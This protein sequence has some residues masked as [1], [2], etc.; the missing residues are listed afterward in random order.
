MNLICSLLEQEMATPS[1]RFKSYTDFAKTTFPKEAHPV[2]IWQDIRLGRKG[3]QQPRGVSIEEACLLAFAFDE[4]V[5]RLLVKAELLIKDGWCLEQDVANLDEAKKPGRP[6][7]NK[8]KK[9]TKTVSKNSCHTAL[10][11][12][13]LSES[14][15]AT[16]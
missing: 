12:R 6:T 8:S 1:P 13:T 15:H 14:E 5:D 10:L 4:K 7:K 11:N 9:N 3:Q 2:K 16:E